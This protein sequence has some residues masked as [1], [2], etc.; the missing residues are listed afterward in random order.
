MP[1]GY[2]SD[3]FMATRSA[4]IHGTMLF[5]SGAS[6]ITGSFDMDNGRSKVDESG[7]TNH[8]FKPLKQCGGSRRRGWS[9]MWMDELST[10]PIAD[11]GR[12]QWRFPAQPALSMNFEAVGL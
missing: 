2:A 5:D 3:A 8:L 7:R 10:Y 1:S 6:C 12:R 4:F 9:T 11:R